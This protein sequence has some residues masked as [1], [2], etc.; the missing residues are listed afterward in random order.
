MRHINRECF[1]ENPER[2]CALQTD[3]EPIYGVSI[4]GKEYVCDDWFT[5]IRHI[6]SK[7]KVGMPRFDS[8]DSVFSAGR[9]RPPSIDYI[10][11]HTSSNINDILKYTSTKC[12]FEFVTPKPSAWSSEVL[13]YYG[14]VEDIK[15]AI[16]HA[17]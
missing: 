11:K 14:E 3:Y 16:S 8:F 12:K 1:R 2:Y 7:V 6:R 4:N 5:M 13:V 9:R 17:L 10:Y 15:E